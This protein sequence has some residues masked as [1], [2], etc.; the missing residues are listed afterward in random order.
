MIG[1]EK[2]LE[3]HTLASTGPEPRA[4]AHSAIRHGIQVQQFSTGPAA[5]LS[6]ANAGPGDQIVAIEP[7]HRA[8]TRAVRPLSLGLLYTSLREQDFRVLA[9]SFEIG[10]RLWHRPRLVEDLWGWR[11]DACR[12][13]QRDLVMAEAAFDLAQCEAAWVFNLFGV[14]PARP[15]AR[16]GQES[17]SR[18]C[19]NQFPRGWCPSRRLQTGGE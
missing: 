19:R 10:S 12:G 1:A 13:G 17:N 11:R 4:S 8:G 14:R 15:T 3:P 18:G 2:G 7:S 5:T 9:K 6:L 16:Q